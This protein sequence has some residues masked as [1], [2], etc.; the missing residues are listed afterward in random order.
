MAAVVAAALWRWWWRR[1]GGDG[2]VVG[3]GKMGVKTTL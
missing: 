2:C 1:F 3:V